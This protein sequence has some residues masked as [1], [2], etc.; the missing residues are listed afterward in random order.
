MTVGGSKSAVTPGRITDQFFFWF[1]KI[2]WKINLFQTGNENKLSSY[3]RISTMK[4]NNMYNKCKCQPHSGN[5]SSEI[6]FSHDT[7][8]AAEQGNSNS[9]AVF[10]RRPQ[11]AKL[12]M[13]C[14]GPEGRNTAHFS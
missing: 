5:L 7:R 12:G 1:K 13:C 9:Q 6:V 4:C 3:G 11:Q 8:H 14:P 2:G 10:V